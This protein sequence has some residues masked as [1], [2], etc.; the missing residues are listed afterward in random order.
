MRG[1]LVFILLS[2]IGLVGYEVI[3]L[4]AEY[5]ELWWQKIPCHSILIGIISAAVL[6]GLAKGI[7][8]LFL[9]RKVDY[10]D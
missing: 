10:Y 8:L 7:G 5:A 2:L 3:F 4:H 1:L 9:Y 6:M